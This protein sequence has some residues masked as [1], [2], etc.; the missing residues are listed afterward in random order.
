MVGPELPLERGHFGLVP[1]NGPPVCTPHR[2]EPKDL[3]TFPGVSCKRNTVTPSA[4]SVAALVGFY[5]PVYVKD[6][7]NN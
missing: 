1:V 6:K 5:R 4:W 7:G 2:Q 3:L